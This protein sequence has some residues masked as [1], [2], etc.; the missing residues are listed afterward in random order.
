MRGENKRSVIEA[1]C[2]SLVGHFSVGILTLWLV[3]QKK[4]CKSESI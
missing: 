2:L 3:Q 1:L 4:C